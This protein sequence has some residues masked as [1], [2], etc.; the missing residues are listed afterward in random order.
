M[1]ECNVVHLKDPMGMANLNRMKKL[2]PL[3][4]DKLE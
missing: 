1:K 3:M 2:I 4:L